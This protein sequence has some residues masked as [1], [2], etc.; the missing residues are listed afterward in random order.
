[1]SSELEF[2]PP[3]VGET[4]TSTSTLR[5]SLADLQSERPE[6]DHRSLTYVPA[7]TQKLIYAAEKLSRDFTETPAPLGAPRL[8]ALIDEVV[9]N[10]VPL[11][12]AEESVLCPHLGLPLVDAL[13]EDHREVRRLVELLNMLLENLERSIGRAPEMG[14]VLTA[15]LQLTS[16][17]GG[18]LSRQGAALDHLDAILS[19][20]ERARLA[21]TLGAAAID[22]RERT[23]LIVRPEIPSTASTVLRHR[24]DLTAAYAM[25]LAEHD[26]R[27]HRGAAPTVAAEPSRATA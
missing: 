4:A 23:M 3:I 20:D 21:A 6:S 9:M 24:P 8:A 11:M 15:L 19:F 26:R 5:D 14:L 10:L 17:L 13:R 16:A 22:A 7:T 27:S 25:S 2:R 1:M 12:A 18:L